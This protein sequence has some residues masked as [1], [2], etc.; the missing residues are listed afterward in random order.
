M[1]TT[2]TA[3]SNHWVNIPKPANEVGIV[4]HEQVRYDQFVLRLLKP[5]TEQLMKLHCGLGVAGEAGELADVVK[6]EQIYGKKV[7]SE[8]KST[9]AGIIE[10]LGDLYFYAQGLQNLY[11]I[12]DQEVHQ[13]NAD[14]LCERYVSLAYSDEE[15]LNRADKG[16]EV[17]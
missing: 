12:T 8:G 4:I 13:K 16:G 15:A 3:Q 5:Q 17:K 1:T 6:R 2:S 10:E 9:R 7:D 14:K 11:G